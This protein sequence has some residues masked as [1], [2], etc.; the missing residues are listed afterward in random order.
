MGPK[1][2][3]GAFEFPILDKKNYENFSNFT[4][5][6]T[7]SW[8]VSARSALI[9]IF[10]NLK[11]K[12]VNQFYF[13]AFVCPAV[14]ECAQKLNLNYSYYPVK[15]DL[16]IDVQPKRNSAVLII[17]YFG[18]ENA[19]VID[20]RKLVDENIFLIE[21][22]SQSSLSPWVQRIQRSSIVLT[23]ARKFGPIPVGAWCSSDKA[24][25]HPNRALLNQIE[26]TIL[27]A[28]QKTVYLNQLHFT[29]DSRIETQIQ[30]EFQKLEIILSNLNQS[31][32]LP[33]TY[34]NLMSRVNW[35]L[36]SEIRR[37]NWSQ[38]FLLLPEN[39]TK[40]NTQ[41]KP[42]I[43]PLGLPICLENRDKIR[44]KLKVKGIFCPI[45]WQLPQDVDP[46]YFPDAF[47]L[48][49]EILTLPVDQRYGSTE[50]QYLMK[51]LIECSNG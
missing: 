24:L 31:V 11:L 13:P 19:S 8:H 2:I 5:G 41:L 1:L 27:A 20:L 38:L 16:S 30:N 17:H 42:D 18:W 43:V 48:S 28:K 14:I 15:K 9:S 10:E 47:A 39:M 49:Q 50:M 3:G 35:A 12:G 33:K 21:D 26:Q 40:L 7:G 32:S 36:Y 51:S 29:R 45:H 44:E 23:N 25:A 37:K 4:F 22:A 46:R 34:L 6:E